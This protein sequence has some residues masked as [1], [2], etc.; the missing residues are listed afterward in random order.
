MTHR[1]KKTQ[2]TAQKKH[3]T[4]TGHN[5]HTAQ[6][7]QSTIQTEHITKN[8]TQRNTSHKITSKCTQYIAHVCIQTQLELKISCA[9]LL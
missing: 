9:T 2:S 7:M 1:A 5:K 6:H 8:H 4:K 3:N